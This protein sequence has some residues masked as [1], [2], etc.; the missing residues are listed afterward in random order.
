MSGSALVVEEPGPLTLVQD[1]GRPGHAHLGVPASGALDP[2][3]LRL[4]NRLVGNPEHLA[5]LEV[6][7]GGL[8][9]RAH[10]AVTVALA[11]APAMLH[12]EHRDA[13]HAGP[14][15]AV[16]VPDGGLVRVDAPA[17][18]LRTWLAVRGGV[19]TSSLLG[20]RS[21]DVLS[22]LGR[23]LRNGDELPVGP[24]PLHPVPAVGQA[25]Q[26]LA[27]VDLPVLRVV[28]GPRADWFAP[29]ALRA[30]AGPWAVTSSS[31][32]VGLR[33]RGPDLVRA[34]DGVRELPSEGVVAGALQVP[35]DGQ[36]VLFLAD[37]PV[38]GGY[39][40]IA[41]VV[42]ADLRLAAQAAPGTYLRLRVVTGPRLP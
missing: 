28:A 35:A 40:V 18:G 16:A 36:P 10:G 37:H 33:L 5:G 23:A 17:R 31:D 27:V 38:T 12:V 8:A 24:A 7:L 19:A 1:L 11:G 21:T 39:P 9:L 20:S 6:L 2:D 42:R 22:G 32:R 34:P 15:V 26:A 3:A 41:T 29:V 14:G 25:P 13:R 30:L 4:A